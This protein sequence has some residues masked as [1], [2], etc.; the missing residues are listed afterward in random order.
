MSSPTPPSDVSVPRCLGCAYVLSGLSRTGRCPECSREFDLDKSHTYT[1]KEPFIAWR[2]WLPALSAAVA[3]GL[4]STV[5]LVPATGSWPA[6]A[7]ISAPFAVGCIIGYRVRARLFLIPLLIIVPPLGTCVG[8]V[9][10]L[11]TGALSG[12]V[13]VSS[14]FGPIIVVGIFFV[15]VVAGTAAGTVL[16][17]LLKRTAFSQRLHLPVL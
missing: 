6:S 5:M 7:S 2:F 9:G 17:V 11:A 3:C 16:R 4:L 8:L 1:T 12:L 10:M 13:S 15:P 14:F